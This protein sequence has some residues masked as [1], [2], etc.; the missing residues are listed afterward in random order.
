MTYLPRSLSALLGRALSALVLLACG[1]ACASDRGGSAANPAPVSDLFGS[2]IL[3]DLPAA[4]NVSVAALERPANLTLSAEGALLG[5]A[6]VNQYRGDLDLAALEQGVFRPGPLITTR[7]AG[8]PLAM[9]IEGVFLKAL[10]EADGVRLD[11]E[12]LVL[13]RAGEPSARLRRGD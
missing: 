12:Q 4:P 6:G 13:T 9:A 5:N 8:S 11:G 3:I 7:M 2:W 10:G 1:F